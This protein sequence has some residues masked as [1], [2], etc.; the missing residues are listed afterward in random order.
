MRYTAAF[1]AILGLILLFMA[2]FQLMLSD[3]TQYAEFRRKDSIRSMEK[4]MT[5]TEIRRVL[6]PDTT[7]AEPHRPDL[8]EYLSYYLGAD[9]S[10]AKPLR[11]LWLITAACGAS[12]LLW[13]IGLIVTNRRP[14]AKVGASLW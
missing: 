4:K 5:E 6:E 8:H 3:R 9:V 7:L 10:V 12:S 13:S 14:A 1:L 11:I 2:F